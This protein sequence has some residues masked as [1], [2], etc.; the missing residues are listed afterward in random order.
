[1]V[2]IMTISEKLAALREKMQ[3]NRIDMYYIP[4]DDFHGSEYVGGYFKCREY[5][6]GFTGSAG[7]VVITQ[8]YAGLWTDGRYYIQAEKQLAG[9]EYVL[10]KAGSEGVSLRYG[11]HS[12]EH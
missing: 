5:I 12:Q 7:S 10:N 8:N 9:T 1:M 2:T 11:I 3:R 6:S 4:T